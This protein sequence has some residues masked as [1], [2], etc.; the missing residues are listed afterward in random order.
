MSI[1]TLTKQDPNPSP[2]QHPAQDAGAPESVCVSV[3]RLREAI[4][5]ELNEHFAF[6]SV[7][8]LV[9]LEADLIASGVIS[10]L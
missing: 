10:R 8:G 3:S 6:S 2:N 4:V 1:I 9:K 7:Q 5:D